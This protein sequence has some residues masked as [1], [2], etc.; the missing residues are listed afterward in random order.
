MDFFFVNGEPFLHTKTQKINFMT[1]THC[2]SRSQQQIKAVL[3]TVIQM[4]NAR[5]FEIEAFH[6]DNEFDIKTLKEYLLSALM[7]IYGK[8]EHV[9]FLERSNR[10]VKERCRCICHALPYKYFTRLMVR[11]LVACAIKWFAAVFSHTCIGPN[12]PTGLNDS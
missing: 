8:G 11:A 9:G 12:D 7:N 3:E 2:T 5:G 6:G 10:F 4:Y 1:A